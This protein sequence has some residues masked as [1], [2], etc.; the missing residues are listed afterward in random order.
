M[1]I[2]NAYRQGYRASEIGDDEGNPYKRMNKVR[3]AYAWDRGFQDHKN[4]M[5]YQAPYSNDE[6][7]GNVIISSE[8]ETNTKPYLWK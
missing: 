2:R 3:D 1:G 4:G 8:Y 5:V 7:S 6:F